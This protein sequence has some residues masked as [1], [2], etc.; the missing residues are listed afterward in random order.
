MP[1]STKTYQQMKTELDEVVFALQREVVCGE[2]VLEYYNRGLEL[3][4]SIEVYLKTAEN[5]VHMLRL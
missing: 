1:K 5:K 2:E 4:Q 3:L